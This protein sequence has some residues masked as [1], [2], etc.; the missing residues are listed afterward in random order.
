VVI[1]VGASTAVF[2]CGFAN[3][4][5]NYVMA[6]VYKTGTSTSRVCV[7]FDNGDLDYSDCRYFTDVFV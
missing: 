6:T 3:D 1:G 2:F 5:W 7:S 4:S